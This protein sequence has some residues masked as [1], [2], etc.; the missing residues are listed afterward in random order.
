MTEGAALLREHA[1]PFRTRVGAAFV[2]TRAVF[3]GHDLH[4]E[5]GDLGWLELCALGVTG[6][7]L[8]PAELRLLESMWVWTSY[9]DARIWNNRV[10]ALA[11]TTRSTS[12]L[13]MSAGQAVS[14]AMIY[15]R[16][17]EFR[18]VA[19]FTRTHQR[20]RSGASLEDCIRDHLATQGN[21]P[22]YGRPLASTDE[23]IAPTMQ[24]AAELGLADG[25]HV[26][27]AFE[28]ERLLL[29]QG[30]PL[31]MNFGALVAAFGADFGLSPR[32]F[33]LL[34]YPCFLAGMQPCYLEA[35]EK[36]AQCLF[37]RSCDDVIYEGVGKRAWPTA[38]RGTKDRT[39]GED[40]R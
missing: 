34:L 24:R 32:E 28:V 11:G 18:A 12:A 21:L 17:N 20:M 10:A 35:L 8:P 14:E 5:L 26:R 3:R 9:P 2:G 7:R 13:A 25:Q 22:G 40:A 37:V 29:S 23:R 30:R 36:P 16:R 31:R 4:R 19:F 1:G 39:N 15:G 33:T 6:R 27:L 38:R